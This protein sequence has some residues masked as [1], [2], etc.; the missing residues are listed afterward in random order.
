[1]LNIHSF[2]GFMFMCQRT[3]SQ[4]LLSC[5]IV[6]VVGDV[7]ELG[8]GRDRLIDESMSAPSYTMYKHFFLYFLFFLGGG[9]HMHVVS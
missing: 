6:K 8:G 9:I 5:A 7:G 1:M 4:H 2:T 3:S